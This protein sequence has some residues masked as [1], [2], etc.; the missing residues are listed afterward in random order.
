MKKLFHFFCAFLILYSCELKNETNPSGDIKEPLVDQ[1][2]SFKKLSSPEIWKTFNSLEEMQK[3]TQIPEQL[4]KVM[5]TENLV[6][7]CLNYPL[8]FIYTAYNN[9][10]EGIKVIMNSFNGF[11]ELKKRPDAAHELIKLYSSLEIP[12]S[13]RYSVD[14][15]SGLSGNITLLHLGYLE[16]VL[17]SE[18]ISNSISNQDL[19][20][21]HDIVLDK[22]QIKIDNPQTYS[23]FSIRKSLLLGA[24]VMLLKDNSNY[25]DH[26]LLK[27][28]ISNGGNI[29]SKNYERLSK[30]IT[31][32]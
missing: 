16:L 7:T 4:L 2:Y 21:L 11:T 24:K 5:S 29:Q 17:S 26:L 32:N 3:A 6:K 15:K 20:E 10:M 25:Q 14:T 30:I 23:M 9:E 18:E 28:F 12:I 1:V 19:N 13:G 8:F 22:Y 31:T 27:E